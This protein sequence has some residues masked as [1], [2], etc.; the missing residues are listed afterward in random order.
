MASSFHIGLINNN[1]KQF[2]KQI[3]K[4]HS[5]LVALT[6]FLTFFKS[7]KIITFFQLNSINFSDNFKDNFMRGKLNKWAQKLKLYISAR[8]S[9]TKNE[10]MMT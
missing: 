1:T 3:T 5:M 8:L 7:R 10:F 4:Q 6:K 2:K 9:L